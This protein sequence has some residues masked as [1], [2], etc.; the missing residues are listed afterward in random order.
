M[1]GPPRTRYAR[2]GDVNIA[3]QVVG[4]GPLD[5]L[6]VPGWF[7]HLDFFWEMG[8]SWWRRNRGRSV[9]RLRTA[10]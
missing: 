3:Y 8:C 9:R 5:L 10:P 6:F 1:T 4:E 2:N 7:S